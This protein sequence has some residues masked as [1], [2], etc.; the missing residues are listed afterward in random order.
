MKEFDNYEAALRRRE[1]IVERQNKELKIFNTL[2]SHYSHTIFSIQVTLP[3]NCIYI[4]SHTVTTEHEDY[5]FWVIP[6]GTNCSYH[7]EYTFNYQL[8]NQHL[9]EA[10]AAIASSREQASSKLSE[11]RNELASLAKQASLQQDK[12][13][14]SVREITKRILDSRKLHS[15]EKDSSSLNQEIA[16]IQAKL[17][18]S[19]A[20]FHELDKSKKALNEKILSEISRM[21]GQARLLDKESSEVDG[22]SRQAH[23]LEL[24][25]RRMAEEEERFKKAIDEEKKRYTELDQEIFDTLKST[26]PAKRAFLLNECFDRE[27]MQKYV[28][29]IKSVGFDANELACFAIEKNHEALFDLALEY[30][31]NC[32]SYALNEKTLLQNLISQNNEN[33]VR[34]ILSKEDLNLDVT[35]LNAVYQE[36]TKS[37]GYLFKHDKDITQKLING[38]N[39]F[40][41]AVASSKDVAAQKILELDPE[42]INSTS[43]YQLTPLEIAVRSSDDKMIDFIFSKVSMSE[44]LV[45]IIQKDDNKI[46][47]KILDKGLIDR[48][49]KEKLHKDALEKGAFEVAETLESYG[50]DAQS[51]FQKAVSNNEYDILDSFVD[52]HPKLAKK[53]SGLT[54][55]QK[56]F[57]GLPVA[58]NH[59]TEVAN[60]G[61]NMLSIVGEVMNDT[62]GIDTVED[63][64]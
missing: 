2:N 56:I 36:D 9:A 25:N 6:F 21:Q 27:D 62:L 54:E 38:Y 10:N 5:I 43:M 41:R 47:A 7:T 33:F 48:A 16:N 42:A 23:N 35:L 15:N 32:A 14:D 30:G 8:C 61:E 1:D 39:M 55:D 34:K 40:H 51:V 46:L 20:K 11:L 58:T 13:Y 49:Q 18:S 22:L 4:S 26:T 3:K 57:M 28:K 50:V 52:I 37:L 44:E 59:D 24:R 53:C 45:R 29:I 12:K 17:R 63:G 31:A 64:L 60:L 19:K